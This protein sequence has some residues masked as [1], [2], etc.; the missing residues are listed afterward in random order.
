MNFVYL[1]F[2]ILMVA[3]LVSG[4][5]TQKPT[6]DKHLFILKLNWSDNTTKMV[7]L[8]SSS[9]IEGDCFY[10]GSYI[11]DTDSTIQIT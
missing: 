8:Q 5:P 10:K 4:K 6:I 9:D 1:E 11:E 7:E 2:A 3:I